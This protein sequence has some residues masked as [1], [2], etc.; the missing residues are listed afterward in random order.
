MHLLALAPALLLSAAIAS[1]QDSKPSA[2][3]ALVHSVVLDAKPEEVWKTFTTAEGLV[4]I[5]GVA[6]A[7]VDFRIGGS[8]RT[9]YDV[10]AN[11]DGPEAIRHTIVSFEPERSF[12]M[13]TQA[14]DGAPD[15][16]QLACEHAWSVLRIEPVGTERTRLI[17]SGYGYGSGELWDRA[18]QFFDVGNKSTLEVTRKY[19]ASLRPALP[20]GADA[21]SKLRTLIGGDWIAELAL[22]DGKTQRFRQRFTASPGG[23]GLLGEGW[24]GSEPGALPFA[25][26]LMAV[27]DSDGELFYLHPSSN[28]NQSRGTIRLLDAQHLAWS[29]EMFGPASRKEPQ[30]ELRMDL[31]GPDEYHFRLYGSPQEAA[32]GGKPM[33]ALKFRRVQE[34][35]AEFRA[36][37]NG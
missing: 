7:K 31:V 35:P 26:S 37:G 34:L 20:T 4:K 9:S 19:F 11:L 30:R 27:L 36:K 12:T 2:A 1:T 13:K 28:G 32:A 33:L 21:L 22:P 18:Y 25:A 6:K 8:I 14:P 10:A 23:H 16:I 15:F 24:A 5:W 29:W 17:I 3:R